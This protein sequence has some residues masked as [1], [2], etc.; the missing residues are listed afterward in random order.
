MFAC[1]DARGAGGGAGLGSAPQS[2][3]CRGSS[4]SQAI[5]SARMTAAE[6]KPFHLELPSGPA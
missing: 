3:G 4:R 2:E 1:V 6:N 5:T